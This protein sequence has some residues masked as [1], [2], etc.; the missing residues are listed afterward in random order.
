MLCF[1]IIENQPITYPT[2]TEYGRYIPAN[3]TFCSKPCV[4]QYLRLYMD[5]YFFDLYQEYNNVVFH[6]TQIGFALN[7]NRL[8]IRQIEPE[9]DSLTLEEFH[10]HY[11]FPSSGLPPDQYY[12][13]HIHA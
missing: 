2:H 6:E 10:N 12:T 4:K 1:R 9:Q 7:P 13:D 5:P 11:I 8:K 3:T